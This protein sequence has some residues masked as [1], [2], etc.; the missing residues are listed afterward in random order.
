VGVSRPTV[1]HWRK[2]FAEQGLAGLADRPRS[3]RPRTIGVDRRLQIVAATL[4]GPQPEHG[5]THWSSRRLA[6]ELGVGHTTVAKVWRDYELQP[7][8]VETFKF[9]TD[10]ELDAKVYDVVGLYLDPPERAVLLCVDEK[11]QI[12]ALDRTAP[13]LPLRPGLAERHT[14]DY[15]RHGTATLFAALE[16]ATG[17]VT[18]RCYQ[19]HRHTESLAFLQQ[20]A[21]AYPRRKLHLVL[22][23][24]ATHKHL[25]VRAWLAKHP[26]I[27]LHFT[28]TSASWLNL[29]E[30][31]FGILTRQ[32]IRRG[33]FTSVT[34]LMQT[35]NAFCD[36]WNEHC[37][38]FSWTKTPE[39]ILGKAKRKTTSRTRH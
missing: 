17:R 1:I 10:P 37:Q 5:G 30:I 12:Q 11:S 15:V 9:S 18:N 19:R 32:A 13:S 14:H 20:I 7:W 8:R 39:Q 29:V 22:D 26:R 36:A 23:N 24:Y 31:F 2:R 28:P 34:D 35:I 38:P 4:A 27:H 25:A 6:Q 16:V 21:K 33:S 3:G